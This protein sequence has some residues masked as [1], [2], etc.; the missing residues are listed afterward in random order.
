MLSKQNDFSGGRG[1]HGSENVKVTYY[2]NRLQNLSV[3]QD[4]FVTLNLDDKIDLNKIIKKISYTHPVFDHSAIK[5]QKQH[6]LI[7]GTQN[8]WYC[9]AYWRNGFHED[10]VWSAIQSIKQFTTLVKHEEL[11]LQR[12]S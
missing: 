1:L 11:H 3:N 6:A 7:N 8:T 2:M 12:A 5:A 10:G 4:Y 9:G